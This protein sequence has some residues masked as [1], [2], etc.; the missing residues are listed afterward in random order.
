MVL[1]Y[2][3]SHFD[4]FIFVLFW[5]LQHFGG[6]VMKVWNTKGDIFGTIA[7]LHVHRTLSWCFARTWSW[8]LACVPLLQ[9][10][11]FLPPTIRNGT[12]RVSFFFL[13]IFPSSY[14]TVKS[15]RNKVFSVSARENSSLFGHTV[16]HANT[17]LN[18][19]QTRA[20]KWCFL[21]WKRPFSPNRGAHR[22]RSG[23]LEFVCT[24]MGETSLSRVNKA[25]SSSRRPAG[26]PAPLH[27]MF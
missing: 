22:G 14:T 11:D 15:K 4:R 16:G 6:Y 20:T 27:R 17:I 24:H 2:G 9:I 25:R 8:S 26:I 13:A 7:V 19:S 3:R 5:D 21:A 12:N 23:P 10:L 18:Y 1:Y